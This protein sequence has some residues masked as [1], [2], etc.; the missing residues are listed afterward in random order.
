MVFGAEA[1]GE[2]SEPHRSRPFLSKSSHAPVRLERHRVLTST[3]REPDE[4]TGNPD[5]GSAENT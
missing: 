3:L 5:H 4:H 2:R 1:C